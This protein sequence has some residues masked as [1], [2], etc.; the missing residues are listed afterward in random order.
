MELVK[1]VHWN[2]YPKCFKFCHYMKTYIQMEDASPLLS[3]VQARS[4]IIWDTYL[5]IHPPP[6]SQAVFIAVNKKSNWG[7]QTSPEAKQTPDRF[8]EM[9]PAIIPWPSKN[10]SK[11]WICVDTCIPSKVIHKKKKN[12]NFF[13]GRI[14][15]SIIIYVLIISTFGWD[16]RVIYLN[17]FKI[18]LNF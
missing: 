14:L 4:K 12:S 10:M 3:M 13:N 17:F 1:K 9:L 11:I 5:L 7:L 18:K 15:G 6:K 16:Y 8:I 2:C